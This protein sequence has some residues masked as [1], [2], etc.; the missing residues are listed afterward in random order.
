MRKVRFVGLPLILFGILWVGIMGLVMV[1]LWNV[2]VPEIFGLRAI[3]F[4]Q[5]LGLLLLSRLLFGRFGGW[6]RKIRKTPFVR[7]LKDLTPEE[8]QRFGRAMESRCPGKFGEGEAA[9][10]V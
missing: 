9:G 7:G 4:W 5:A 6:G 1:V 2:L 10:K 8:R 3:G